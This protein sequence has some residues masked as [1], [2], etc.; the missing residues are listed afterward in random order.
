MPQEPDHYT[1]GEIARSAWIIA[2]ATVT[3]VRGGDPAKYDR[4]V[5]ALQARAV[6]REAA[7]QAER[8]AKRRK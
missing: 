4:Q 7:E 3:A 1:T 2:K 8:D 5:D 6:E